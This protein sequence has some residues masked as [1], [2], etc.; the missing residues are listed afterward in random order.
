[1]TK[2]ICGFLNS[3][4]GAIYIGIKEDVQ[5]KKR[6]VFGYRYPES[7]KEKLLTYFRLKCQKISPEIVN[8]Q[9]YKI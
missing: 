1:L 7:I 6:T 8:F 4:G 5:T 9:F 3:K 2:T